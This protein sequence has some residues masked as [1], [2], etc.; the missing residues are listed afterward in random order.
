MEATVKFQSVAPADISAIAPQKKVEFHRFSTNTRVFSRSW[1]GG[2]LASR[3]WRTKYCFGSL[4]RGRA[5]GCINKMFS[6]LVRSYLHN[7][8]KR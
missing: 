2:Y 1:E 3:L 8:Y 6:V 7:T 4:P 5:R